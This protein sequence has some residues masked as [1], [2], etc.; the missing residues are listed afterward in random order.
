LA[1]VDGH[2]DAHTLASAPNGELADIVLAV[3]IGAAPADLAGLAEGAERIVEPGDVVV[4]GYRIP[5]K[6]ELSEEEIVDPRVQLV[7]AR[8]CRRIDGDLL[9]AYTADRLVAQAGR[10]WVHF[11]VDVLDEA[12]MP[13]VTYP[14]PGGL[15]WAEVVALLRPLLAAPQIIGLSIADFTPSRDADGS[16]LRSLKQA[17]RELLATSTGAPA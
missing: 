14:Q 8:A 13:A 12:A 15:D 11:D 6:D 1:W 16:S 3:L 17:L 10:L 2:I 9:G 4:L 7:P 5:G